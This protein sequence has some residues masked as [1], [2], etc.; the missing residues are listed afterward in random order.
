M[1]YLRGRAGGTFMIRLAGQFDDHWSPRVG[2]NTSHPDWIHVCIGILCSLHQ[3]SDAAGVGVR[4]E[5]VVLRLLGI[6]AE[7][8]TVVAGRVATMT[9]DL[10][11][12]SLVSVRAR[13]G[14]G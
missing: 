4:E 8:T 11:Y 13:E 6:A 2:T 12:G 14:I 7:A 1:P 10:V 9:S 5:G 3:L